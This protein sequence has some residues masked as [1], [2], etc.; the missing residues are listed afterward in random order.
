LFRPV[1]RQ[2][3]TGPEECRAALLGFATAAFRIRD[4]VE[5]VLG[6]LASRDIALTIYDEA[7]DNEPIYRSPIQP[8]T[9]SPT[10]SAVHHLDVSGRRWRLEF[11][12][13]LGEND[14]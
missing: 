7:A 3:A 6:D 14:S 1:Y 12:S 9:D 13:L 8:A 4:T 5:R 2:P 11:V 10:L